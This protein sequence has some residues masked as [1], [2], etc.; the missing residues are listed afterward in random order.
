LGTVSNI[1]VIL[2]DAFVSNEKYIELLW[3]SV[4]GK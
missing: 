4:I 1:E 3:S 2:F